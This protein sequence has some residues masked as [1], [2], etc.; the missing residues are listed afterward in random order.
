MCENLRRAVH[1]SLS[2]YN[3]IV[4]KEGLKHSAEAQ[5]RLH[6]QNLEEL[7][8]KYQQD[9]D[10]A[11]NINSGTW[12]STTARLSRFRYVSEK[13]KQDPEAQRFPHSNSQ[14]PSA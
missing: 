11:H 4:A 7:I 8:D 13:F 2:S 5:Q 1:E 3:I 6:R 14:L 10:E 12:L 9:Y